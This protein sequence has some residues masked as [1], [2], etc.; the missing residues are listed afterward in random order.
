MIKLVKDSSKTSRNIFVLD[1]KFAII[2]TITLPSDS[3]RQL[4]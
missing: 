3:L 1:R 2:Q 4:H